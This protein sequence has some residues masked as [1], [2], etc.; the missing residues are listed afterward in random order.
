MNAKETVLQSLESSLKL[1]FDGGDATFPIAARKIK[2]ETENILSVSPSDT[3]SIIFR[4]AV[5]SE[6]DREDTQNV[7][8]LLPVQLTVLVKSDSK[9]QAKDDLNSVIADVQKFC[10]L[11]RAGTGP[12]VS[13]MFRA[14]ESV[15][16]DPA[17]ITADANLVIVLRYLRQV[18]GV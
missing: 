1:F 3:P 8:Y 4:E 7:R 12:C 11:N 14:V 10:E 15:N 2:R 13:I 9:P 17:K 16:V 6:V 5:N 18:G